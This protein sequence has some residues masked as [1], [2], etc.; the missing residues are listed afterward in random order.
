M[1]SATIAIIDYLIVLQRAVLNRL[2]SYLMIIPRLIS[3]YPPTA[4]RDFEG[5]QTK[6]YI[7]LCNTSRQL[8]VREAVDSDWQY[9]Y[10]QCCPY[11]YICI[12]ICIILTPTGTRYQLPS[13]HSSY[14]AYRMA[15]QHSTSGSSVQCSSKSKLLNPAASVNTD[16]SIY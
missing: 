13:K 2:L 3:S 4:H 16:F 10:F 6:V 12:C 14:T 7:L 11:T 1:F 15:L 8:S 9:R 5:A